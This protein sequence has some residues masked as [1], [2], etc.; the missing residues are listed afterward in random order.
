M[1]G[2]R[3][4]MTNDEKRLAYASGGKKLKMNDAWHPEAKSRRQKTPR[5]RVRRQKAK[6][7][8]QSTAE[9]R[10]RKMPDTRVIAS[11]LYPALFVV[12]C[13]L[14]AP[15]AGEPFLV[16]RFRLTR[17]ILPEGGPPDRLRPC[18]LRPPCQRHPAEASRASYPRQRRPVLA[19]RA[20][21]RH[22]RPLA[23]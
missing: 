8:R 17:L 19:F 9:S 23:S 10:Q 7:E 6:N 20:V 13:S 1:R 14:S 21:C 4:R 15:P 5:V 3:K 16:V 2:F 22:R 18:H 12:R 11:L